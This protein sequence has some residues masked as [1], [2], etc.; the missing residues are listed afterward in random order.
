MF[1]SSGSQNSRPIRRT[2]GY[3]VLTAPDG[4]VPPVEQCGA[5]ELQMVDKTGGWNS[6]GITM[7]HLCA[8]I[9]WLELEF[10]WMQRCSING[11][12]TSFHKTNA[13]WETLR[14]LSRSSKR[15]FQRG[16]RSCQMNVTVWIG[17]LHVYF[18]HFGVGAW[19]CSVNNVNKQ[20]T[21]SL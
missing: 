2:G 10:H 1:S 5:T 14:K 4:I 12:L 20:I 19:Y 11:K 16:R 7:N 18:G 15:W 6:H 17:H 3:V 13:A 21:W 9:V 8:K